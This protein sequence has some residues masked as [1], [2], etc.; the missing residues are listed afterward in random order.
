MCTCSI[1]KSARGCWSRTNAQ[2]GVHSY[3]KGSLVSRFH[4]DGSCGTCG[5]AD[6]ALDSILLWLCEPSL[7]V[8]RPLRQSQQ[9]YRSSRTP[10]FQ[11][12]CCRRQS[13][14]PR[15]C[16]CL[17]FAKKQGSIQY[18]EAF[19]SHHCDGFVTCE[20]VPR[21]VWDVCI[22][23]CEESCTFAGDLQ[24]TVLHGL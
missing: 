18:P 3:C 10:W 17:R 4:C 23:N 8:D 9:T 2:S 7:P 5:V 16:L 6:T 11:P 19:S 14:R 13:P 15:S 1:C 20:Y 24:G 21:K 22:Y 12:L